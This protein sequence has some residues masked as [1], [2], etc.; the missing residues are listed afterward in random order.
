M[1]LHIK[2]YFKHGVLATSPS[3]VLNSFANLEIST[4]QSTPPNT[5]CTGL[6]GFWPLN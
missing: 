6:V 5:T 3:F 1:P 4:L 2:T